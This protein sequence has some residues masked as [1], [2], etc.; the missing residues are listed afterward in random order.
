M[1]NGRAQWAGRVAFILAAAGSAVGLGNIWRFPFVTGTEGGAAFILIYLVIVVLIGYPLLVTEITV[2]R[3]TQRNPVGAFKALAPNT[4]WWLVGALG[5]LTAFVILSYYSVVAGWSLAYTAQ[6]LAGL[7]A[8]GV[9]YA[10]RFVGHI[11][12]PHAVPQRQVSNLRDIVELGV[13]SHPQPAWFF[14]HHAAADRDVVAF[15]GIR[16]MAVGE[17]VGSDEI[18]V[19]LDFELDALHAVELHL[20]DALDPFQAR[21][22]LPVEQGV[23][24]RQVA[25]R[26]HAQGKDGLI[27][28]RS[29]EYTYALYGVWEPMADGVDA[30]LHLQ[31][32]RAHR[33]APVEEN[34]NLALVGI[35]GRRQL[36]D[37]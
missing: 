13:G 15:Q 1:A 27:R 34:L 7:Y 18:R 31:I 35:G 12:Q 24:A 21:A 28:G 2:G 8:P 32:A 26:G 20:G 36:F 5:V 9:D 14:E 4:P 37:A 10:D 30:C 29:G 23:L 19:E 16:H 11:T 6:S 22:Q 3:A 33:F 17:A 25:V